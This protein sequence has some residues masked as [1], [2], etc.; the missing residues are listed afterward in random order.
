MDAGVLG[1]QGLIARRKRETDP[2]AR[3]VERCQEGDPAAF[4]QL[5]DRCAAGVHR[6]LCVLIG[7]GEDV[8][9]LIQLVFLNVF[10]SIGRF[11]GRSAFSTWLFRI[12]VNVAR[13][14]IR[15]R[16]RRRRLDAAVHEVSEVRGAGTSRDP[17]KQLSEWQEI[18]D[19]LDRLPPKKRETYVLYTYEG[20]S[21]SDIAQLLSSSISTIGSRLQSARREILRALEGGRR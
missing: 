20:F 18:Y 17:E 2:L 3:V 12:T 7:P 16:K 8:D 15:Q 6:H 11:K 4:R 5:Y 19:V 1:K 13:Q 10:Q 14:E 21:L 9:D